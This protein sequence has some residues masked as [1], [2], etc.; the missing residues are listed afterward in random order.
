MLARKGTKVADEV[1]ELIA[2]YPR[3]KTGV[4]DETF[5]WFLVS[6]L[7]RSI[8]LMTTFFNYITVSHPLI[9]L[10]MYCLVYCCLGKY[11]F[12]LGELIHENVHDDEEEG[13]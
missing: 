11:L 4:W 8:N 13:E 5:V 1:A 2:T 6:V 7:G 9:V 10:C 3:R 12:D